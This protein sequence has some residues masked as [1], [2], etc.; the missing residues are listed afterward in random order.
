MRIFRPKQLCFLL[1]LC[2]LTAFS[3]TKRL[4]KTYKTNADVKVNFDA[5]H[6]NVIVENWDKNEVQIE[7][8]MDADGVDKEVLEN[9]KL[10][11]SGNAKEVTIAS[12]G[13]GAWNVTSL[14]SDPPIIPFDTPIPSLGPIPEQVGPI[15]A[16]LVA[17]ILENISKN[18]LP[19]EFYENLGD[20]KF[21]YEAYKEDGEEYMQRFEQQ[22]EKNFGEDFEG[23]MKEWASRFEIN[24]EKWEENFE[25]EMEAWGEEFGRSMAEWGENFGAEMEKWGENLDKK[26]QKNLGEASNIKANTRAKAK[27]TIKVRLPVNAKL[28]LNVRHG[29]VQL[30]E[31][32]TN[33]TADLSHSKLSAK[34]ID[35][36][37]TKVKAAYTTVTVSQWNYGI[38]NT[39][40][41]TSCVIDKARSIKLTSNSSDV[42]IREIEETGILSGTFGKLKIGKLNPEFKNLDIT[43][44]NSD[45]QLSLPNTALNFNYNGTQSNIEYPD[46]STIN[47]TKSYNNEILNGYYKSKSGKANISINASYSDVLVK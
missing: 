23:S 20:L 21:D 18:P 5:R 2:S 44:A 38:L 4:D 14:F 32:T 26:M 36:E 1:V 11:T 17:P 8:F 47:A 35:G 24:S 9:W 13:A 16:E 12:G 28:N 42:D 22:I 25:A 31:K 15:M 19:P 7:A 40:Y 43:L 45:L 41:V 33:L 30:G 3:Q 46:A 27:R 37:N 6:T 10:E 34:I 39:S 29:E